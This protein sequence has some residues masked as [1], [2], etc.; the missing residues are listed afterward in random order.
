MVRRPLVWVPLVATAIF[1]GVP[2]IGE[3]VV[4]SRVLPKVSARIGRAVTVNDV[5]VG[6]G[7]LELRGLVVD[8]AGAAPP[9]VIPGLRATVALS[10]LLSGGVRVER[11]ELDRPRIDVVRG[12]SG[13]DN[14]SSILDKL[15]EKRAGASGEGRSG[16]VHVD[17]VRIH[18]G[19]VRLTDDAL[20]QAEVKALD[21]DLRPDGPA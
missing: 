19:N 15:K 20:G 16:G 10:S 21:G 9:V 14:V 6:L 13:D 8:G 2:L 4:R 12:E 1:A 18:E 7:T 3:Y 11:L 5:K 17:L